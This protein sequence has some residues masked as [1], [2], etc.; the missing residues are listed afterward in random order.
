MLTIEIYPNYNRWG[1]EARQSIIEILRG[2][3]LDHDGVVNLIGSN[4]MTTA[5]VLTKYIRVYSRETEVA[6]TVATAIKQRFPDV[7]VEAAALLLV[8]P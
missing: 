7:R 8:R 4:A 6:V 1:D 3:K 2:M 5:G